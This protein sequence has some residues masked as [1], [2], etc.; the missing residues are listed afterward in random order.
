MWPLAL[1][2]PPPMLPPPI[3]GRP[4]PL[5]PLPGCR[6]SDPGSTIVTASIGIIHVRAGNVPARCRCVH[7]LK[8]PDILFFNPK[9][10]GIGQPLVPDR[11]LLIHI[12]IL[13]DLLEIGAERL[14]ARRDFGAMVG[15][16][17]HGA[18]HDDHADCGKT[19]AHAGQNRHAGQITKYACSITAIKSDPT[20]QRR[21]WHSRSCAHSRGCAGRSRLRPP[22]DT[23]SCVLPAVPYRSR[24]SDRRASPP[25]CAQRA[26]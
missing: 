19:E 9:G 14:P 23:C 25:I 20:A 8:C 6:R 16:A 3:S 10:D 26:P 22:L 2:R 17:R 7:P 21:R 5:P 24:S 4:L 13:L 15:L 11:L 18:R 1:S 12:G